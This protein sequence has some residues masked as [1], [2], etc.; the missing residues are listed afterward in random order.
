VP[1]PAPAPEPTPATPP[2]TRAAGWLVVVDTTLE[3][4]PSSAGG[5]GAVTFLD[6]RHLRGD[7]AV[8]AGGT[9]HVRLEVRSKPTLEPVD[10]GVC[11]V[12]ANI[13]VPP[14]CT[15]AGGLR[16]TEAGTVVLEQ[17]VDGLSG[18]G[19][20]WQNGVHQVML[21]LR[22]PD[23]TPIDDR[24]LPGASTRAPIVASD[25]F[26]ME[27]RVTGILVAPG[28]TFPGWP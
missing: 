10:Y 11:L 15:A 24:L 17:P 26:P 4:Q 13:A 19:L 27:V 22:R 18:G 1:T 8:F 2:A 23:G 6:T 28:N 25:Y 7:L 9:L 12:Q 3:H 14:A 20:A 5:T 16:I 21:V